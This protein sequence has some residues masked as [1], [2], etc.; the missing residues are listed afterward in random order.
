MCPLPHHTSK[1][2]AAAGCNTATGK[3]VL[4]NEPYADSHHSNYDIRAVGLGDYVC[5]G[6]E[7]RP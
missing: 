7:I 1:G 2:L 4:V 5:C 6:K 3:R